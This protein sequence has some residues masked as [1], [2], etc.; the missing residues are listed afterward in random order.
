VSDSV[1]LPIRV[2][3]RDR[4]LTIVGVA[5]LSV[6]V[7]SVGGELLGL[8]PSSMATVIVLIAAG[9]GLRFMFVR[10]G[11]SASPQARARLG[12]TISNVG[13]A[14]SAV[15]LV[16]ALPVL[17]HKGGFGPFASN[18]FKHLW[19]LS[20]LTLAASPVRTLNW[21]ALVGIGLTGFL[22][23]TGLSRWIGR[24]VIEALGPTS[25]LAK[26]L[27]VPMTEVVCLALP[28]LLMV[29]LAVRR[30]A[31]RPSAIDL[32]L[33]GG[34]AGAGFAL[35]EDTQ[36][37]R[38]SG[39]W[40]AAPPFSLLFPSVES[41]HVGTTVVAAGHA[42][43]IA[44]VGLGL[45][46][47]LLYRQRYERAWIAIPV[48]LAVAFIEHA[49]LNALTV[50]RG[51][52]PLLVWLMLVVTLG[53]WLSSILLVGGIAGVLV[54]EWRA[55]GATALQGNWWPLDPS[56]AHR[57]SQLLAVA[58]SPAPRTEGMPS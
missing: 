3:A 8:L 51:E 57:R 43:W 15:I 40:W 13:L 29:V 16:A 11:R 30:T 22:G 23:L 26:A 17:T 39:A 45:G 7:G 19:T 21:R 53:G 33:V 47:G 41:I 1:S 44:L 31:P 25:I 55:I 56:V 4:Q 35:Y 18:L 5:L 12:N 34:W 49:D 20:V 32:A 54:I 42:V 6:S 37:G 28:V 36:F 52:V 10:L 58:Q 50:L 46:F 14:T 38:S 2:A 27:W 48:A 24:P 9:L